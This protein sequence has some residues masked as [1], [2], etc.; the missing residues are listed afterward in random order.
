MRENFSKYLLKAV[1]V[2]ASSKEGQAKLE[3]P[4]PKKKISGVA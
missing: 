4:P 1:K 2:T 3:A